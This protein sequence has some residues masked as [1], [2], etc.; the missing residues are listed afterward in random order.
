MKTKKLLPI[1]AAAIIGATALS[2]CTSG[3]SKITFSNNWLKSNINPQESLTETLAYDVSFE[4]G[5]GY[6][7]LSYD[8]DYQ[9]GVY[10]TTLTQRSDG[11]LEYTTKLTVD[12]VYTLENGESKTVQDV[13]ETYVFFADANNGLTPIKS[14]K[15]IVSNTPKKLNSDVTSVSS[16]YQPVKYSITTDYTDGDGVCVVQDLIIPDGASE[17]KAPKTYK[18][19]MGKKLSYLDN[20]QLLLGLRAFDSSTTSGKVTTF[21]AFTSN[22]TQKVSVSFKSSADSTQLNVT[23][24]GE[25]IAGKN[26]NYR[27]ATIKYNKQNS[28]AEQT[29]WVATENRCVI[30]RLETPLPYE[31]G[32]LVYAIKT[33]DRIEK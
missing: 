22:V 13:V 25:A 14:T 11:K 28:G 16:C 2:G 29:A 32:K 27:T 20:E 1:L 18:F 15:S 12:V 10:T 9:N 23:E 24:N 21:N 4:K 26:F 3:D 30:L 31:M 8:F 33:I 6:D 7:S 17:L 19:E 5:T